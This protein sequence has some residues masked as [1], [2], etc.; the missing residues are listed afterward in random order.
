MRFF[1]NRTVG[2]CARLKSGH[3][4]IHA[5]NLFKRNTFFRIIE[6]HQS[7]DVHVP[8]FAV[9]KIRIL[10]EHLIIAAFG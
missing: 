4:G 6:I 8:L 2:H 9:H 5:L 1:G 10:L 3:N 7:T